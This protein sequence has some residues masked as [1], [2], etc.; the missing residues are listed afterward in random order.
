[1]ITNKG[2]CQNSMNGYHIK[3]VT[4]NPLMPT[5]SFSYMNII[6]WHLSTIY[7]YIKHIM[8]KKLF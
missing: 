5:T 2:Y 1:M 8:Y 4:F 3:F 7:T 6:S